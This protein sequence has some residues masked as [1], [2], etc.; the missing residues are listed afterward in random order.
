MSR[1]PLIHETM[2]QA[3][4]RR[5]SATA[6]RDET[7]AWT[8]R[9]LDRFSRSVC[10]WLSA[11]GIRRGE[12]VLV[13]IP[14]SR[15]AVGLLYGVIRYGA[16]C[17]PVNPDVRP[18]HLKS[19]LTDCEPALVIKASDAD[20]ASVGADV[21]ATDIDQLSR[22]L[23][24]PLPERES[25]RARATDIALLM[26]TSGST[27]SPKAVVC[28]HAQ[29]AF[30]ASV[31]A[32]RLAYQEDDVVYCRLPFSFDYGLYQVFLCALASAE[33]AVTGRQPEAAV[34]GYA[35]KYRATVLPL[36]PTLAH[37]LVRLARRSSVRPPVRLLTNTGAELSPSTAAQLRA[38]FSGSSLVLMYGM[39]E[40]KRVTIA[41][42]D[43]DV[44]HPGSVGT[45]LPGTY[46]DVVSDTGAIL[47]PGQ[48]GQIVVRGPHLMDGYWRAPEETA[49]RYGLHPATGERCLFTGD[50]GVLDTEGRLTFLGRRDEIFKRH[51]V[52]TS[53]AELE[54]A[55]LDIPGVSEA[56]VLPPGADGLVHLWVSTTDSPTD[57][58]RA[59][60]ERLEPAKL[61][62][63]CWVCD[64]LPHT[65]HGKVDKQR[66]RRGEWTI[67]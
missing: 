32:E 5:P 42:T 66:L 53:T 40:C 23:P 4:R 65:V 3:A 46:V 14:N 29:I 13:R 6:V 62:D 25:D 30:A 9:Q 15:A 59:L 39:T 26:Y 58:L 22:H 24:E 48:P 19:I 64:R 55:A 8:Y 41:E 20:E 47:P 33:L 12:R 21:P 57:I 2:A 18:Y 37:V 67:A 54:G 34:L 52:R 10:A 11:Q 51:G 17:V 50:V 49:R 44:R 1:A 36:V 38:L 16:I 35:S 45:A 56:A 31:V 60:G 43:D 61:P 28:R 63:H 7:G 27:S